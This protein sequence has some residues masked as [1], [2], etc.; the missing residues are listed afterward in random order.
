MTTMKEEEKITQPFSPDV[1][2]PNKVICIRLCGHN[3]KI[4][5][6]FDSSQGVSGIIWNAGVVLC[7]YF[8]KEAI[9]FSGKKVIELGSGTG[10]VGILA[11]LLG[12][13]V[14]L[15]DQ[16]YALPQIEVNV[17]ANIPPSDVRRSTI[18]ALSW[19]QDQNSFPADYDIIL[20]SELVFH[21]SSYIPLLQTLLHL[22]HKETVIYLC[23]A[24]NPYTMS[25][26]FYHD[27]LPPYFNC[28][29]VYRDESKNCNVY[30]VTKI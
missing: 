26:S 8:E 12:G 20:G 25:S 15:T 7:N 1:L 29:L 21:P 14:T 4:A 2:P 11:A 13:E 3:L 24:M 17:A 9:R 5:I 30:K 27:T 28:Q 16:A 10:L 18:S 19:G 6:T 23:S 22:S